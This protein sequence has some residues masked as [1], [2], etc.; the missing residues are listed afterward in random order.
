MTRPLPNTRKEN[1]LSHRNSPSPFPQT[2]V[3]PWGYRLD[4]GGLRML[5]RILATALPVMLGA[6]LIAVGPVRA[7][8]LH[9]NGFSGRDPFW[10]KGDANIHFEEKAHKISDEKA[11]NATTS[12]YIKVEAKPAPG[13]TDAEY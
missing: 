8:D 9:R 5:R 12:E 7:D 4:R 13:S 11:R 10:V 6:A 3:L 1:R 2:S